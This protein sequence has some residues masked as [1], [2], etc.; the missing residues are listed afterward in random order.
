[1]PLFSH[2]SEKSVTQAASAWNREK[3]LPLRR[4]VSS[5][6]KK[7]SKLRGS[8][9]MG[10]ENPGNS[11]IIYLEKMLGI[12]SLDNSTDHIVYVLYHV[13][14]PETD[15]LITYG[16]KIFPSFLVVFMLI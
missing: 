16:L 8:G 15:H 10:G 6:S 5:L 9:C 11:C 4:Q 7:K 3:P 12:H 2:C 1:M 14:I 13:V